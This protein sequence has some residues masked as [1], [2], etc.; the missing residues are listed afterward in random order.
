ML[1]MKL[2]SVTLNTLDFA[3]AEPKPDDRKTRKRFVIL[4]V[5][6]DRGAATQLFIIGRLPA[7]FFI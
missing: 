4:D 6:G 1:N 5:G 7:V 3:D 2:R